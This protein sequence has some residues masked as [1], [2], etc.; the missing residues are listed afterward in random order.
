MEIMID[1][2][3][4]YQQIVLVGKIEESIVLI[5]LINGSCND[6]RIIVVVVSKN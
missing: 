2:G 1:Y 3:I 6:Y 4:G 5:M